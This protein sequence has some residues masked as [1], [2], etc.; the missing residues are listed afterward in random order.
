MLKSINGF[1]IYSPRNRPKYRPDTQQYRASRII[2]GK[3]DDVGKRP[4]PNCKSKTG[5]DT[6]PNHKRLRTKCLRFLIY[7][8]NIRHFYIN[9]TI[10]LRKLAI[11]SSNFLSGRLF[12]SILPDIGGCSWAL[13]AILARKHPPTLLWGAQY[14]L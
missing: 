10:N 11:G 14:M 13:A 3:S 1:A 2:K 4:N 7:T 5:S 9:F 12:F 6:N 8:S